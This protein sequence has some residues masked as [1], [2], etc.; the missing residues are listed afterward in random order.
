MAVAAIRGRRMGFL[1]R[2]A[3][4]LGLVILFIPAAEAETRKLGPG[5]S[6]SLFDTFSFATAAYADVGGFCG[7]NPQAYATGSIFVSTFEAKA[8]TGAR[9]VYAYLDPSA[10]HAPPAADAI[11]PAN[12]PVPFAPLPLATGSV[13]RKPVPETRPTTVSIAPRSDGRFLPLPPPRRP[14]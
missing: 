14:S 10:S 1:I 13:A 12:P 11:A 2:I 6:M 8:R 4:F 5:Q 3:L 7:R 9:W